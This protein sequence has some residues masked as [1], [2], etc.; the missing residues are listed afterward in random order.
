MTNADWITLWIGIPTVLIS[1]AAFLRTAVVPARAAEEL[2][3]EIVK[4][5]N[6]NDHCR[7]E[8]AVLRGEVERQSRKMSQ[9]ESIVSTL[10]GSEDYWQQRCRQL[11]EEN[12]RLRRRWPR[13]HADEGRD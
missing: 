11:Q 3:A 5:R 6:E 12:D 7:S 9:L 1:L 2:Q 4:L 13:S 10:R 8:Q